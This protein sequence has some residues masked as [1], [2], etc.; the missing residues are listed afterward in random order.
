MSDPK[1]RVLLF[2]ALDVA[3]L[4]GYDLSKNDSYNVASDVMDHDAEVVREWQKW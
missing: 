4:N 3:L 2:K 1:L